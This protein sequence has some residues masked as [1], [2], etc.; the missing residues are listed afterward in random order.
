MASK[1]PKQQDRRTE[2]MLTTRFHAPV[3]TDDEVEAALA[4]IPDILKEDALTADQVTTIPKMD[5]ELLFLWMKTF[6]GKLD[7]EIASLFA[8]M[9]PPPLLD[10][11]AS[12]GVTHK[13]LSEM[14]RAVLQQAP[15]EAMDQMRP[16]FDAADKVANDLLSE[17]FDGPEVTAQ[18]KSAE[19]RKAKEDEQKARKREAAAAETK[20][21]EDAFNNIFEFS[22][23]TAMTVMTSWGLLAMSMS[24]Q[25]AAAPRRR[26]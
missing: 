10:Q 18:K 21:K 19:A 16:A 11:M 14:L 3:L 20:Q 5:K 13:Q 24:Q 7:R 17:R 4:D 26:A 8:M 6:I 12:Q 15:P 1:I 9:I 25:G 22:G 23:A 2:S